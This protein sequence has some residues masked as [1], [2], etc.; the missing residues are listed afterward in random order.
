MATLR[1]A[2]EACEPAEFWEL[3]CTGKLR[4]TELG[5]N[6]RDAIALFEERSP[7][8]AARHAISGRRLEILERVLEGQSL[9][10]IALDLGMANS[11]VSVKFRRIATTLGLGQRIHAL[12]VLVAQ[13][14][15]AKK[16]Y[17]R[18]KAQS[19]HLQLGCRQLRVLA[20]PRADLK[21]LQRLPDAEA[22][23]CRL[24]LEGCS[25]A[26]IAEFRKT[27]LRTTA[28]QISSIFR[29]FRVSGRLELL[30]QFAREAAAPD[31]EMSA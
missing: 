8:E 9:N 20:L 16:P 17:A 10:F 18:V 4:I 28:N 11:T 13:L 7:E 31:L 6:E 5:A 19:C 21:P 24:F 25:H 27:R 12:P 3:L 30:T 14:W 2:G 15:F 1:L 29:K 23:V 22:E 26:E